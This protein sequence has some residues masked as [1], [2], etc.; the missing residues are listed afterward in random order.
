MTKPDLSALKIAP[1]TQDIIDAVAERFFEDPNGALREVIDTSGLVEFPSDSPPEQER[2]F[3]VTH[4]ILDRM[5]RRLRP[6]IASAF[7]EAAREAVGKDDVRR[8]AVPRW[9]TPSWKLY[10]PSDADMTED[11]NRVLT[12]R[13][14]ANLLWFIRHPYPTYTLEETAELLNKNPAEV[15]E[16]MTERFVKGVEP[17]FD[18][19]VPS[20]GGD[21]TYQ[22]AHIAIVAN[23]RESWTYDDYMWAAIEGAYDP[24]HAVNDVPAEHLAA[25]REFFVSPKAGYTIDEAAALFGKYFDAEQREEFASE[26]ITEG[27]FPRSDVAGFLRS[28]VSPVVVGRAL[29]GLSDSPLTLRTVPLSLPAWQL[30]AIE[31]VARELSDTISD[32]L[33]AEIES[34][35]AGL[36]F[37]ST[38][39]DALGTAFDDGERLPD[40]SRFFFGAVHNDGTTETQ[41]IS[42]E[43][44]AKGEDRLAA[45]LAEQ[46]ERCP[47]LLAGPQKLVR[48][49][50]K[51]VAA[52]IE[53]DGERDPKP[54]DVILVE[55]QDIPKWEWVKNFVEVTAIDR[56]GSI[57][58]KHFDGLSGMISATAIARDEAIIRAVVT[59]APA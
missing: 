6:A 47:P 41:A 28:Y 29:A 31:S 22:R 17:P 12:A 23:E 24:W 50:S 3:A 46:R 58:A 48:K 44:G 1:I 4:A 20:V 2:F 57:E 38:F 21:G 14:R 9:D 34:C 37:S 59:S 11:E 10:E 16:T 30:D 49:G 15:Y 43:D 36:G 5:E 26:Y 40:Y 32:V 25:I 54:G 13:A 39:D 55:Q 18:S 27:L 33:A 7:E 8:D 52:I 45:L 51:K 35:A 19:F 53:M 56:D 42:S